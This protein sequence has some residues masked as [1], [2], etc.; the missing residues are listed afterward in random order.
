MRR[1]STRFSAKTT[2]CGIC[3]A[4]IEVEGVLNSCPHKF[5]H[6]CILAWAQVK[7]IQRENRCPVCKLRFTQVTRHSLRVEYTRSH[8]PG[9]SAVSHKDQVQQRAPELIPDAHNLF[10]IDSDVFITL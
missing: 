4:L 10:R 3:L 2:N 6:D 7:K 1:V 8:L 5:C 9:V